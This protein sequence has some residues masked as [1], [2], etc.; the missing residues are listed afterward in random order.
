MSTTY[1][2]LLPPYQIIKYGDDVGMQIGTLIATIQLEGDRL[3]PLKIE[4]HSYP[5]VSYRNK[6]A[7]NRNK[8]LFEQF[9]MEGAVWDRVEL[10]KV[11]TICLTD[12]VLPWQEFIDMLWS[13]LDRKG[14]YSKPSIH[15]YNKL[16]EFGVKIEPLPSG[17]HEVHIQTYCGD[18]SPMMVRTSRDD[19]VA[20]NV[21]YDDNIETMAF[22]IMQ[23]MY[24]YSFMFNL[25]PENK[26][27]G[28]WSIKYT[29]DEDLLVQLVD[30]LNNPKK[31]QFGKFVVRAIE[32]YEDDK[33]EK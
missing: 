5:V 14:Y 17:V 21:H 11:S 16:C 33:V 18:E 10:G 23:Q 6:E 12:S 31:M 32:P 27:K 1:V 4:T 2:P 15:V 8:H 24:N 19:I 13:D 28:K 29:T 26:P 20:L 7:A 25:H 22:D 30:R 9:Y 3:H